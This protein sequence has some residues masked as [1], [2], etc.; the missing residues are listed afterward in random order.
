MNKKCFKPDTS[1]K[2]KQL[3]YAYLVHEMRQLEAVVPI[4]Q[5]VGKLG[6][7]GLSLPPGSWHSTP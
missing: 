3:R 6:L 1:F 7:G 2:L 4:A 5:T